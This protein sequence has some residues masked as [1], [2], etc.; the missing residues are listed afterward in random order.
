MP[1]AF[2]KLA[3]YEVIYIYIYSAYIV[4]R[5]KKGRRSCYKG[6]KPNP[7]YLCMLMYDCMFLAAYVT[8][9]A[10]ESQLVVDPCGYLNLTWAS[11]KASICR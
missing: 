7:H 3:T 8:V 4:K 6:F 10:V 11:F 5:S 9:S 1:D 2:W